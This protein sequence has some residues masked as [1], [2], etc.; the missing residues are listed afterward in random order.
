MKKDNYTQ[1][2]MMDDPG[3]YIVHHKEH[4]KSSTRI[5]K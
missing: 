5:C 4:S 3:I 2:S 1:D